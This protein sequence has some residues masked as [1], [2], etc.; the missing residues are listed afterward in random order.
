MR[1]L[2]F[3]NVEELIFH[4]RA[5]QERLPGHV[6]LFEQWRMAQMMPSLKGVARHAALDFLNTVSPEEVEILE[7]HFGE[8]VLVESLSYDIALN[9]KVPLSDGAACSE[10]C[11]T[12]SFTNFSTWRDEEYLYVSLWR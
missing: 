3:S 5:L 2:N 7:D 1:D 9:I 8:A 12:G 11:R 4:D 10:L 6:G